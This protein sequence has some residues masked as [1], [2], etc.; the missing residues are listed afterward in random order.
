MKDILGIGGIFIKC[1]DKD[2]T[3]EW[4]KTVLGIDM[5]PWGAQFNWADDPS[6]KPYSILGLFKRS[7]D[8]FDPSEAPF[9]LN[10]RV[11]DLDELL[12]K[13]RAKNVTI[14]GEPTAEEYGK[15]AWILD[16]EG[17]KIELFQQI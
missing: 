5:Q 16:P 3:L 8:Y 11:R 1:R 4:Y 6:E 17:N 9:M 2:N 15:F 13:L 7:T 12:V 14:V 10:L